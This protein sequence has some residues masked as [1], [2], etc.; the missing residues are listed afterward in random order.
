MRAFVLALAA[1]ATLTLAGC[2]DTTETGAVPADDPNAVQV[3]PV[4]PV[5][6]ET[7]PVAPTE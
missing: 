1:T 2:G 3:E 4:D 7:D 5:A 6:P